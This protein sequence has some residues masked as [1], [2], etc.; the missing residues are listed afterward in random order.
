MV[1]YHEGYHL[2]YFY[3]LGQIKAASWCAVIYGLK[4]AA[5]AQANKAI[6][7][8]PNYMNSLAIFN[9]NQKRSN[10]SD[11]PPSVKLLSS[12]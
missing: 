8:S 5:S 2:L 6:F 3:L 9:L 10:S 1:I 4:W 12:G 11:S 7:M